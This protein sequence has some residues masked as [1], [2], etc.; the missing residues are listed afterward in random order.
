M[1]TSCLPPVEAP[2]PHEP[3]NFMSFRKPPQYVVRDARKAAAREGRQDTR[4]L[5]ADIISAIVNGRREDQ[6][7]KVAR[8][9]KVQK[10]S[11]YD[12]DNF[13]RDTLLKFAI[14]GWSGPNY[15]K[16]GAPVPVTD[17]AILDL[18]EP[19]AAWAHEFV[20]DM[21]RPASAEE[22]KSEAVGHRS[23]D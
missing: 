23:G 15:S 14:T 7:E 22:S 8:L 13:D 1:L 20:V 12:V 10:S 19:V 3:G 16:D 5:G 17:E 4:D 6:D 21:I 9:K 11:M 18:D 2:I